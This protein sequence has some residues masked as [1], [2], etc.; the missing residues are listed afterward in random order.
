MTARTRQVAIICQPWDN[1]VAQTAASIVI[2]SC[3]LARCLARDW[4]VVIYGRR[5]PGQKPQET[6]GETVVFKRFSVIHRPHA[7]L[8]ILLG[9]VAC[10]TKSRI[11]YPLSYFYHLFYAL[12]VALS[13]RATKCDVVIV[14]NFLQFASIIKRFNPSAAVCMHMHCEWLS[15]YVTAASERRLRD[16]DLIIGCSEFI[17]GEVKSR[18]P[19]IAARCHTVYNGVD[20]NIFCPVPDG[21]PRND[22]TTRLL[23]LGRIIPEWGIHV[24]I[25]A[26]KML[27]ETRPTLRL[28]LVGAANTGR[29][30]YL[31]PDLRDGAIAGMVEAFYGNRLSDMVRRQLSR[32]GQ[33]YLDD[34]A[35]EAAGDERIVF[36]GGV[37][38]TETLDFYRRAAMLVFPAI[39]NAPSPLPTYEAAACGLPIVATHSGGIPEIVEHGRTGLL[40]PRG[41]AGELA[42]AIAQLLDDAARARAMGEAGR[43]RVLERFTW[44]ASARRLA[45]LIESVPISARQLD[46]VARGERAS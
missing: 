13:V 10:Y 16:L 3:Q 4:R 19:A 6:G 42:Q 38:H 33:S 35:A 20:T 43:Q 44:D 8:E 37:S 21:A 30:L 24:L 9:I 29:Y 7:I 31:C 11:K 1:V 36:H 12:R 46:I 15:Y 23:F 2:L 17:S 41:E 14:H 40:V 18:F 27:V 28:D 34:L 32:K 22:G 26:F 39:V 45:D 25:R 5:L